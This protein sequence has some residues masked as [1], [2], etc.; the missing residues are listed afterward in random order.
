M[1][2]KMTKVENLWWAFSVLAGSAAGMLIGAW[3]GMS[4]G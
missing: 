3:V 4:H 1:G 2:R